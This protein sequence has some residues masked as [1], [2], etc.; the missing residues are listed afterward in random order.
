MHRL[1]PVPSTGATP[2]LF[3]RWLFSRARTAKRGLLLRLRISLH[4][5]GLHPIDTRYSSF[6]S[7]RAKLLLLVAAHFLAGFFAVVDNVKGAAQARGR[8]GIAGT[9]KIVTEA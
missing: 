8:T 4:Q 2:S 5:K 1:K 7:R 9:A 3:N 6:C